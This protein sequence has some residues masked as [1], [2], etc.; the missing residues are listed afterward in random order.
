MG[1]SNPGE[2]ELNPLSKSVGARSQAYGG[3]FLVAD[4]SVRGRSRTW[5]DASNDQNLWMALGWVNV[6]GRTF[7]RM[8]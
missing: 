6:K 2:R 5:A 8:I 7:P 1:D 4:L 3:V